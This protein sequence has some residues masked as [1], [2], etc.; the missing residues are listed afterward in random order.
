MSW[1][2]SELSLN[3]VWGEYRRQERKY[4][5]TIDGKTLRD[6]HAQLLQDARVQINLQP[7]FFN[8]VLRYIRAWGVG[9][10]IPE[11]VT[12]GIEKFKKSLNNFESFLKAN[13]EVQMRVDPGASKQYDILC[14]GGRHGDDPNDTKLIDHSYI[15]RN[16]G[17]DDNVFL[18][19]EPY[20]LRQLGLANINIQS[21]TRISKLPFDQGK[22]IAEVLPKKCS[23]Y[24]PDSTY[25]VFLGRSEVIESLDLSYINQEYKS[26]F[27]QGLFSR[28]D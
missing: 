2:K 14:N 6:R 15:W 20:N 10:T 24:H 5:T 19:G 28:V 11:I 1:N 4:Y 21:V 27:E 3:D 8:G 18:I 26:E 9:K 16:G 7:Y 22:L 25:L 13:P 23:W 12:S 17:G